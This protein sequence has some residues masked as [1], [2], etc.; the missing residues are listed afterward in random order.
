MLIF[1]GCPGLCGANLDMAMIG[2]S[3]PKVRP[4][5]A[6][7]KLGDEQFAQASDW[8]R[9]PPGTRGRGVDRGSR[10]LRAV[11]RRPPLQQ[12]LEAQ[13]RDSASYFRPDGAEVSAGENY[14]CGRSSRSYSTA[15]GVGESR[16]VG[17]M[18]KPAVPRRPSVA[19]EIDFRASA[20]GCHVEHE[21]SARTGGWTPSA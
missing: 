19:T 17:E 21:K 3:L 14:R 18:S 10:R 11:C 15:G 9:R 2:L 8:R 20:G 1:N 16:V 5:Q 13:A 4:R 6:G 12:H 7:V